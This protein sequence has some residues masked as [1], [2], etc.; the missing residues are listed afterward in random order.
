MTERRDDDKLETQLRALAFDDSA[1]PGF[2]DDVMHSIHEPTRRSL[3]QRMLDSFAPTTPRRR[4]VAALTLLPAAAA[5]LGIVVAVW[6]GQP[7]EA[8]REPTPVLSSDL[9]ATDFTVSAPGA[10]DVFLTGDFNAWSRGHLR[11]RDD[12]HN[13]TW[14]IM[15]H[16]PPGSYRYQVWADGKP[17]GPRQQRVVMA[18]RLRMAL[19]DGDTDPYAAAL[20]RLTTALR[21]VPAA[22]LF[23]AGQCRQRAAVVVDNGRAGADQLH[24]VH[25]DGRAVTS[26]RRPFAA[27]D[28]SVVV[29]DA[30]RI[31]AGKHVVIRDGGGAYL[32]TAQ[33]V[34]RR[35]DGWH[36]ALAPLPAGCNYRASFAARAVVVGADV[37]RFEVRGGGLMLDPDNGG[38]QPARPL[39]TGVHDFQVALGIDRDGDGVL[40]ETRRA[41][42]EWLYN[43][44]G[45]RAPATTPAASAVRITLLVDSATHGSR[46]VGQLED[47]RVNDAPEGVRW[48][49]ISLTV[50]LRNQETT[51]D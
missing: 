48:R 14:S 38:P 37:S 7:A 24:V 22:R 51:H 26:L 41:D 49:L 45:D 10:K 23:D 28:S 46:S 33:S 4:R 36:L 15:V 12:D 50:A 5:A 31:G 3:W 8:E 32:A 27:G 35:D 17:L 2:A 39:A 13:G 47:H 18:D 42:D 25:A 16:L 9:L 19:P 20:T 21:N 34:T 6:L 40:Y 43:S 29:A 11:M 30:S 1:R 44:A